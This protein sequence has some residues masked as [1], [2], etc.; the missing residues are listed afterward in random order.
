MKLEQYLM[1]L[2]MCRIKAAAVK[3][4]SVHETQLGGSW[5]G[6]KAKCWPLLYPFKKKEAKTH[7]QLQ[8]R[9]RGTFLPFWE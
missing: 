8:V 5:W 7:H 4:K 1:L 9:E 2:K 3:S 6:T